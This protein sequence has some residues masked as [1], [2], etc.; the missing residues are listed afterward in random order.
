MMVA[1]SLPTGHFGLLDMRER[2][3]SMGSH[4]NIQS[5]PGRGT[6]IFLR[7]PMGALDA[8]HVELKTNTYSGG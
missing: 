2:A 3:H 4:L 6:N 8:K 5:E 7:V 1:G